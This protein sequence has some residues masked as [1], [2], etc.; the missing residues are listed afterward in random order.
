VQ[1]E[2]LQTFRVIV[3]LILRVVLIGLAVPVLL[4]HFP[5]FKLPYRYTTDWTVIVACD[6]LAVVA[7]LLSVRKLA[8]LAGA[9]VLASH[10][11]YQH[12]APVWDLAYIA[13]AI[14]LVLLP[15]SGREVVK[16]KPRTR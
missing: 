5:N 11:Y 16:E 8:F 13:V 6:A 9:A 14:V 4:G 10:Y 7:P 2:S 15:V 3:S 1:G 12:S